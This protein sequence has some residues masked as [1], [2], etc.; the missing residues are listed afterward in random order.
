MRKRQLKQALESAKD[1]ADLLA[2]RNLELWKDNQRL[3]AKNERLADEWDDIAQEAVLYANLVLYQEE[4]IKRLKEANAEKAHRLQRASEAFGEAFVKGGQLTAPTGAG[5]PNRKKLT[6]REVKDI[7]D[8]YRGG[9]K[10]KDLA[11]NY[12]VNPATISRLVRGIYH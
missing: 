9:M 3:L 6:Q 5:R 7:R 4:E 8:A 11:D 1:F 12:G 2:Q 10:Q